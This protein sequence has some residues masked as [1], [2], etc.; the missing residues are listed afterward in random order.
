MKVLLDSNVIIAAFAAR[1]LCKDLFEV[2][3][4]HHDI[5]LSQ[6]LLDEIEKNLIKKI[7]LPMKV[8]HEILVYLH[9]T[10]VL[11]TITSGNVDP[12]ICRDANDLKV[13]EL[14][15]QASPDCVVTGDSDL[16]VLKKF[17][18]IPILSPRAFWEYL[19]K[20]TRRK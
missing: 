14:A 16:L 7:K 20:Q 13:L 6:D 2:C 9:R 10:A 19:A 18:G 12:N 8:T 1:G 3:L 17:K 4:E 5:V 15:A 11:E